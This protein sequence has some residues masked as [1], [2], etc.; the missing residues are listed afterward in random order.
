[1]KRRPIRIASLIATLIF[2]AAASTTFTSQ[3]AAPQTWV[4]ECRNNCALEN[5]RCLRGAFD[6]RGKQRCE[7]YNRRCLSKCKPKASP[8]E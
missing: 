5:Q 6:E 1:M 4:Q 8:S 2:V 7:Y 3:Q